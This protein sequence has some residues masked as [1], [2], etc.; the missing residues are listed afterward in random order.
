MPRK[1]TMT[2]IMTKSEYIA[3]TH[4][5]YGLCCK[6]FKKGKC[7]YLHVGQTFKIRKNNRKNDRQNKKNKSKN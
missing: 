3:S 4:W 1:A 6:R 2:G 5:Q 7:R